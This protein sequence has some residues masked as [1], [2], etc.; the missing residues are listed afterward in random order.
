MPTKPASSSALRG[1]LVALFVLW[2][3]QAAQAV[4]LLQL[5]SQVAPTRFQA[6]LSTEDR[7]W[8]RAHGQLVVGIWGD[9]VAPIQYRSDAGCMEGLAADY[10]TLV[11]NT[12]DVP[13]RARWFATH[14]QAL[15]ALRAHEVA[16]VSEF[17]EPDDLPGLQPTAPYLQ[18]PL[19]VV[20]RAGPAMA[21]EGLLTGRG[22][23]ES[24]QVDAWKLLERHPDAGPAVAVGSSFRALED[25][26]LGRADYYVGDLISATYAVEQGWFL[27]LRVAGVQQAS[28]R[29]QFMTAADRPQVKRV[30]DAGLEA[31]RPWMRTSILRSWTTDAAQDM[32]ATGSLA[33]TDAERR[34][35]QAN[36]VVRVAVDPANAPYTFIDSTGEF[37]GV[38][39]DLLRMV[40]RRTGLRFEV[41]PNSTIAGLEADVRGGRAHMEAMLMPTA[42][43]ER[44]LDFTSDVAPVVWVLVAPRRSGVIENMDS[45]RGKRLALTRGHGMADWIQEHYPQVRLVK[46]NTAIEAMDRVARGEADA[47]L[48]SMATASYVIERYFDQLRIAGTAFDRPQMARFGVGR[49]SPELLGILD[50]ALEGMSPAERAGIAARWLANVNYPTSTWESLRRVVFRWL[51]WA[52]G[53]LALALLWNSLLQYQIRRRRQAEAQLRA[54]KDLAERASVE[55]SQFLAEMSHEIRTPMSAVIGLLEMATRRG[56]AGQLDLDS[57]L[58]AELSAKGLLDLVG[59]LLDL[60]KIEAG[61]LQLAVRPVALRALIGDTARLFEHAARSKGVQLH[62]HVAADVPDWVLCDPL[63]LRQV[64]SNLLSNAVKFTDEGSI[65][66]TVTRH[67]HQLRVCVRDTGVG[68]ARQALADVFEPFRQADAAVHAGGGTGLGLGIVRRLLGLMGGSI[69]LDS[70]P[71]QGTTVEVTLPCVAAADPGHAEDMLPVAARRQRVLVVDDHPI[72]LRVLTDQLQWLGYD[73]VQANSA[74][75]ALDCLHH[76]PEIALLLTDCGMPGMSGMEL[77]AAAR[78]WE[79]AGATPRRP[80]IGYTANALPEARQ[81]CVEAGMDDVLVKPLDITQLGAVLARW[82]REPTATPGTLTTPGAPPLNADG[83]ELSVQQDMQRLHEAFEAQRWQDVAELTHRLRGVVACT[84]P[85][86]DLE[87]ACLVLELQA[88]RGSPIQGE[89]VL[90]NYS[91][92]AD[93][94]QRWLQAG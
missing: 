35:I 74:P 90:A 29:F 10:L 21:D 76:D 1:V 16:A 51:P 17:S 48:Q 89:A 63:R 86:A 3:P 30:L 52:V 13:V 65:A 4:E 49:Q 69:R 22:V 77:V 11:G 68:I 55:K 54:A 6:E 80:M 88:Q 42:E 59:N 85:D 61:E 56:Q 37:A 43:R 92:L 44:F 39:A 15:A 2:L 14:A 40:G 47:A 79:A 58:L 41:V 50:R 33:L 75:R 18:P 19:A 72:N 12:L 87:Q 83:L 62:H 67:E 31:I 60:G 70:A 24:S 25:V 9:D 94:V 27:N 36:P 78:T 66:L 5:H 81:A 32:E 26:S 34:W 64:I 46:V 28:T 23:A 20:R 91:R 71:G 73:V 53:G 93:R 82:L 38:Y 8:L 84:R 45:L 7:A 57:L